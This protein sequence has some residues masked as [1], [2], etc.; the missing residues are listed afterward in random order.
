MFRHILEDV[1]HVTFAQKIRASPPATRTADIEAGEK[2]VANTIWVGTV[3][4]RRPSDVSD[5]MS[6]PFAYM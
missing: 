1:Q 6:F 3:K 5:L 2:S 4:G